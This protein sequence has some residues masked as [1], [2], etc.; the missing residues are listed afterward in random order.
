M[1]PSLRPAL[2]PACCFGERQSQ[3]WD[4]ARR[5]AA[6]LAQISADLGEDG[7]RRSEPDVAACWDDL[8]VMIEAKLHSGNHRLTN[9]LHRFDRYLR[10]PE[11]WAA[12]P[13]EIKK[14]GF[15]ELVRNWVI[16]WELA[17]REGA[18][19]AVLVNL[20][21]AG[22]A[23]DVD[24]FREL[25]ADSQTRRVSTLSGAT[26][27]LSRRRHGSRSTHSSSVCVRSEWHRGP[28]RGPAFVQGLPGQD[29]ADP[30]A[31]LLALPAHG[32]LLRLTFHE[33]MIEMGAG[34]DPRGFQLRAPAHS[35]PLRS[36][37]VA[38]DFVPGGALPTP[39][40]GSGGARR[41]DQSRASRRRPANNAGNPR[42]RT[43]I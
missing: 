40:L 34:R 43:Q 42:G 17:E 29:G 8:V 21:P 39:G 37:I 13:D 30:A 4:A 31:R 41:R 11:L 24:R 3:G 20:A 6:V 5:T 19:H 1:P 7:T 38:A 33:A 22:H 18:G 2:R 35:M 16:A 10:R 25:V 26:S 15:Y 14:V 27:L 32:V 28:Q 9:D 23:V 12:A 36:A